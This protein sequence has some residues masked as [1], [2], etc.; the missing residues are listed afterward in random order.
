MLTYIQRGETVPAEDMLA[1]LAH[2]LSTA[3]VPL[4]GDSTH[5]TPLDVVILHASH[6]HP[7]ITDVHA[8]PHQSCSILSTGEA[9][10]PGAGAQGTELLDTGGA[11]DWHSC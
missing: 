10:V 5:G 3:R 9:R 7:H 2:H 8:L 11:G 6:P 4:N 1:S